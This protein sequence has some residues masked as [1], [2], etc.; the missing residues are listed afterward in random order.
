M[1][2]LSSLSR[3]LGFTGGDEDERDEELEDNELDGEEEEDEE[4]EEGSGFSFPFSLGRSE[5][6]S[7]RRTIMIPTKRKSRKSLHRV[8][9]NRMRRSRG[10][11]LPAGAT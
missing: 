2:I 8:H 7:R 1:N 9:T 6:S 3:K 10:I 11:R 5:K 4:E